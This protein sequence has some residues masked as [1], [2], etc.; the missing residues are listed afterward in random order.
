MPWTYIFRSLMNPI[1][2][3]VVWFAILRLYGVG[4]GFRSPNLNLNYSMIILILKPSSSNTSSIILF[5]IC[6]WITTIQLS[7]VTIVVPTFG[8]E[9]PTCFSMVVL[10]TFWVFSN[11]SFCQRFFLTQE[12]FQAIVP[13]S[14]Y[15]LF[16]TSTYQCLEKSL[17]VWLV[18]LLWIH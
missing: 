1:G 7:I 9:E 4:L 8:I 2:F 5:P 6:T 11:F 14:K 15:N 3:M 17:L 13:S 16:L 12:L 10:L 18:F